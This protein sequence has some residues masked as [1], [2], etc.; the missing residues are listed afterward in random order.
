MPRG[1]SPWVSTLPNAKQVPVFRKFRHTAKKFIFQKL[2]IFYGLRV[3][4]VPFGW[5][6]LCGHLVVTM[7]TIGAVRGSSGEWA[8]L[9]YA[10]NFQV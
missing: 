3:L 7:S 6:A 8:G 5:S 10:R 1:V 9:S 4:G 2:M